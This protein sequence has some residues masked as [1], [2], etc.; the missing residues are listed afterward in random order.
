MRTFD[1][2]RLAV[3]RCGKWSEVPSSDDFG[4]WEHPRSAPCFRGCLLRPLADAF[5]S[6]TL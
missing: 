1:D 5:S 4:A 2:H 3:D 6:Q